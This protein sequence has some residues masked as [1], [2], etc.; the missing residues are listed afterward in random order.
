MKS[1]S[2]G[3]N[4]WASEQSIEKVAEHG[5]GD[6]KVT[7]WRRKDGEVA[8]ETNGDPVFGSLAEIWLELL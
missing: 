1:T 2:I 5:D 7:C 3:I 8:L 4:K 6:N